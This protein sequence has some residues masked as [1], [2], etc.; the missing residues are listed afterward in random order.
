MRHNKKDARHDGSACN[1]SPRRLKQKITT[2]FEAS[3]HYTVRTCLKKLKI[4]THKQNPQTEATGCCVG[5][6]ALGRPESRKK[7]WSL[8]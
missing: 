7:C 2:K 3:L 1:S 5:S 4:T 8:G 6:R